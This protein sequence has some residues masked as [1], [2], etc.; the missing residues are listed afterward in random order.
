MLYP[1]LPRCVLRTWEETL[2]A[3]PEVI[4]F[5]IYRNTQITEV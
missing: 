1:S 4:V 3:Q 2:A 5:A